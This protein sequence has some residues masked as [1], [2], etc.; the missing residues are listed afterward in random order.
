MRAFLTAIAV[1]VSAVVLSGCYMSTPLLL[2]SRQAATPLQPGVYTYLTKPTYSVAFDRAS[3]YRVHRYDS[4]GAPIKD[5][6]ALVLLNRWPELDA[7][8]TKAY[9][10]AMKFSDGYAYGVLTVDS[11]NR[12]VFHKPNCSGR[13]DRE[14]AQANS[15]TMQDMKTEKGCVFTSAE[16]LKT[17]MAEGFRENLFVR[18]DLRR[19]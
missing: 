17:A 5:L 4:K 7:D 8:G 2:D 16:Q 6:G 3:W 15:A 10:V 9:A 1:A 18:Q 13:K 12:I 19:Q 11:Y 14:L